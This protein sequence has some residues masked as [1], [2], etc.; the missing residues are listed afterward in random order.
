[1][2]VTALDRALAACDAGRVPASGRS[3][4]SEVPG[5]ARPRNFTA[6]NKLDVVAEYVRGAGW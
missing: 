4:G 2:T 3:A 6:Q 5:E 1:M